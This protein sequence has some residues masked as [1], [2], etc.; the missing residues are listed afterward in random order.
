MTTKRILATVCVT[1]F[2][3]STTLA[4]DLTK[5]DRTIVREPVYKSTPK[6]GLLVFGP[7]ARTRVWLVKDGDTLYVD[8]NGNG[9]LTE[10]GEKVAAKTNRQ[11]EDG[12][13]DFLAGEIVDGAL[14]HKALRCSVTKID[15][16]ADDDERV[17]A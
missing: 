11:T 10:A 12:E 9:D 5:V 7:E 17:K 14:R 4:A 15:H 1:L 8:R 2:F 16:L 13:F 3:A 6:Y